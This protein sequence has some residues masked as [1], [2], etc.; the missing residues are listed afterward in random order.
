[1]W[2]QRSLVTRF[3]TRN[4]ESRRDKLGYAEWELFLPNSLHSWLCIPSE[5]CFGLSLGAST[6]NLQATHPVLHNAKHLEMRREIP[7]MLNNANFTRRPPHI[8]LQGRAVPAASMFFSRYHNI[9]R[10]YPLIYR[11]DASLMI[12]EYGEGGH[13]RGGI[14]YLDSRRLYC[15]TPE[16]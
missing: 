1:M 12:A 3:G 14:A 15:R 9:S 13:K 5:S 8:Q 4:E 16:K 2:P 7:C 10:L 6:A 11:A